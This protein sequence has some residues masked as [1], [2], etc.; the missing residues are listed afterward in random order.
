MR[1]AAIL[2]L[3]LLIAVC[4]AGCSTSSGGAAAPTT[5]ET[6]AVPAST[7]G[8][9]PDITVTVVS[10]TPQY[11]VDKPLL[12][13]ARIDT[14]NQG[15]VEA[16]GVVIAVN[17]ID[18]ETGT[19]TDTKNQYVERFLPGEKKSFVISLSNADSS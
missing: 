19:I 8:G 9:Q 11:S 4:S 13:K 17:L 6:T 14:E 5:V 1:A 10:L 18:E 15:S 2:F 16:T 3:I 7:G 12:Y